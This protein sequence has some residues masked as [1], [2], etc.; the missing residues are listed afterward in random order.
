M[1]IQT[2]YDGV[3]SSDLYNAE[4]TDGV[5]ISSLMAEA[6]T[7]TSA[8]NNLQNT[9]VQFMGYRTTKPDAD[10]VTQ[11]TAQWSRFREFGKPDVRSRT[12]YDVAVTTAMEGYQ[13]AIEWTDFA[14]LLRLPARIIRNHIAAIVEGDLSR[15]YRQMWEQFF[16]AVSRNVEDLFLKI[17]VTQL[18]FYNGDSRVPPAYGDVT[19]TAPHN[20]YLRAASDGVI[21]AADLDTLVNTVAEHGFG[22]DLY[23]FGNQATVDAIMAIT[24]DVIAKI[25]VV[26]RFIPNDAVNMNQPGALVPTSIPVNSMFTVTGSFKGKANIAVARGV[27]AGYIGCFSHQGPMSSENP[28]QV[29]D[30]QETLLQGLRRVSDSLLPFV[31]TYWQHLQGIST[32][33]YGNGAAMQWD[34]S[35]GSAYQTPTWTYDH[36]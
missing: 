12:K 10:V 24:G 16:D 3:I 1:A 34:W 22:N 15:T 2:R 20:H 26:N 6:D 25:Q 5:L 28:L 11:I 29:R 21:T 33:Q 35:S 18:P 36:F 30:P 32:R 31:G 9:M 27:P 8:Y 13:T 4:T 19:F 17:A 14:Q 7:L 23:I